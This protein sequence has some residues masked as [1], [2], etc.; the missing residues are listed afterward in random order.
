MR[1]IYSVC[2]LVALLGMAACS[3]PLLVENENQP[4][5][6]RALSRPP[7]VETFIANSY[8]T[9]NNGTIG[10]VNSTGGSINDVLQPGLLV[11]GLESFSGNANFDMNVR[12]G[13]PRGMVDNSRG[14]SGQDIH[15]RDWTVLH[16]AARSA[17]IGLSRINAGIAFGSRARDERNKSFAWFVMGLG[18]GNLALVYDS[19][20]QIKWD[21]PPTQTAFPLLHYSAAMTLA[22]EYLDSAIAVAQAAPAAADGFPLPATWLNGATGGFAGGTVSR[23]DFVRFIRSYKARF[24]ASVARDPA[25]RGAVDWTAVM[26]DALAGITTDYRLATNP[27]SGWTIAWPTQHYLFQSWH[28]MWAYIVGMADSSGAYDT[29]LATPLA[30]KAPFLVQ[31]RDRRFPAGATRATQQTNSPAVPPA[32][33]Y[34]RNR[35]AGQDV[36]T[37]NTL[38]NSYYDFYRF[39]V[40]RTGPPVST[41]PYPVMTRA[42][43]NGLIAEGAIRRGMWAIAT[44]YIDSSRVR[45]NLPSIAGIADLTTPVPGGA[46]CVPKVPA[47]PNFTSTVC[48]NILEA[49]KWEYRMETAFTGYGMWYLAGRGWGD[50][51][52]GT[53]LQHPV[54]YQELD[55]RSQ[56]LYNIGGVGRP[57]GAARGT[58][59][60]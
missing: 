3:E 15:L 44:Q 19:V 21:D 54:P 47:P 30:S 39:Q 53:P 6:D 10:G 28:Q 8:A 23:D 36:L 13:V 60:L 49:M 31:T 45:N 46:A 12:G 51:P 32:T 43:M 20:S 41:G 22:L 16:R 9:I 14:N 33:L 24:R 48:G 35:P 40:W 26:D 34:F 29:W 52:E 42:E 58:Y 7:D 2:G 1:N 59:G 25:E 5:R 57:G 18:V 38:A 56:A 27:A 37:A 17:A 11:M 4:E 50:L 55:V